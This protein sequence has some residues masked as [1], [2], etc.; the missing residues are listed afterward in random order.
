MKFE[1]GQKVVWLATTDRLGSRAYDPDTDRYHKYWIY[2]GAI[3]EVTDKEWPSSTER[4]VDVKWLEPES[5][6]YIDGGYLASSFKPATPDDPYV[7]SD[8]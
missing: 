3:A 1:V 7:E 2:E 4:W 6:E 8:F 5:P